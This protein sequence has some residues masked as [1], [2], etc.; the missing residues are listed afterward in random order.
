EGCVPEEV[1]TTLNAM[2]VPVEGSAGGAGFSHYVLEWSK[3]NVIWNTTN[4][5]YPPI[6]P[7]GGTQG[8]SPVSSGL[9]AYF[10]TTP[11]DSGHYFLRLTVFSTS[12]ATQVCRIEFSLFKQDVRILGV[13]GYTN[14]N[15]PS[16]DPN[17]QFVEN[18]PALCTR[19][20]G[21]FEVSFAECMSVLGSAFVGGCED[22]KI[23]RYT[24]DYK[25][26]FETDCFTGGWTNIW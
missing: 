8:N 10:D 12:G 19:P 16:A 24:I 22:K 5:H 6:P 26:G 3:D 1:N 4:F 25:P 13:S 20:A 17:A 2:V 15:A 21:T 9:L 18:V 11:L 7:G 23:K 14:L